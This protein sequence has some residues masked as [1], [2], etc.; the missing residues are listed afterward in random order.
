MLCDVSVQRVQHSTLDLS[1]A[2][3]PSTDWLFGL[4]STAAEHH[5]LLPQVYGESTIIFPLL[6]AETFA[7][8]YKE[9]PVPPSIAEA[10]ANLTETQ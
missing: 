10:R 7:R 4:A 9:P 5:S 2:N 6:V 8:V 1:L 3:G